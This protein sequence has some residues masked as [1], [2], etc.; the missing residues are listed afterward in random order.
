[1]YKATAETIFELTKSKKY[2]GAKTGFFSVLHTWA[3][4]LHY[5]PHIHIALLG[6][7]LTETGKWRSSRKKFFIPVKVLAKMFR[8][9]FLAAISSLYYEQKLEF[10]G[11]MSYLK[12]GSAFESLLTE[13]YKID[14][15]TYTKR[16]FSGPQAV[17]KYLALYTHRVAISNNRI[18][19]VGKDTVSFK[20]RDYKEAGATKELTLDGSEF[21]R[22]FLMHV[23]PKGLI[24]IRYYGLLA[25][26][27]RKTLLSICQK[28]TNTIIHRSL[29]KGLKSEEIILILYARD[30]TL[31]PRCRTGKLVTFYG[32]GAPT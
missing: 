14:W 1:M 24:K 19:N 13:L 26:C 29:Y 2:L 28:L 21:I 5:H 4:D 17:V 27:N 15:Y 25:S 30:V 12:D 23:L 7:G 6:G 11:K 16:A 32:L 18:L 20:V 31:C 10:F 3:Q 22:R 9:K 8:G